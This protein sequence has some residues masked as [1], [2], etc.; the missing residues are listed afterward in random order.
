MYRRY[1]SGDYIKKG[2]MDGRHDASNVK[3]KKYTK[4]VVGKPE[5]RKPT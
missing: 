4:F 2:M 1:C 3:I 5:G